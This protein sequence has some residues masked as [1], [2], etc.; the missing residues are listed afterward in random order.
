MEPQDNKW[1]DKLLALK[2]DLTAIDSASAN[3]RDVVELDQSKVGRLSRM[4]AMQAQAMNN[5]VAARR[6]SQL[7][8]IKAALERLDEGE[9]GY[10]IRCGEEIA[11]KR[12]ELDPSIGLCGSCQS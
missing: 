9:F 11:E 4:D 1:R 5:A 6:K 10:C 2:A 8:R 3:G 7:V 12:L